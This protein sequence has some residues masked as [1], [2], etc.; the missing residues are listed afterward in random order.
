MDFFTLLCVLMC[1]DNAN[2]FTRRRRRRQN[3]ECRRFFSSNKSYWSHTSLAPISFVELT[4]FLS[5]LNTC[6]NAPKCRR[7]PVLFSVLSILVWAVLRCLLLIVLSILRCFRLSSMVNSCPFLSIL[8]NSCQF[9]S[10][11]VNSR[12]LLSI[13]VHS[14]QFS[15]IYV[16]SYQFL[17]KTRKTLF[18]LS[19]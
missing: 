3:D 7:I 9:L 13:L 19:H 15:T 17:L 12:Q 11:L 14:R 10:I 18:V 8:V 6:E 1:S 16:N 5:G 4:G 2:R